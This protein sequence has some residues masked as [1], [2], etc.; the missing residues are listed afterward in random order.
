MMKIVNKFLL[1]F[2]LSF[3]CL[4]GAQPSLSA[5]SAKGVFPQDTAILT[6]VS[7]QQIAAPIYF[8]LGRSDIDPSF[9]GNSEQIDQFVTSLRSILSN[10][11]YVISKVRVVGTAS[12]DGIRERNEELAGARARALSDLLMERASLPADKIEV[13]NGGENWQGLRAMIESSDEVPDKSKM[14]EFMDWYDGD[15]DRMKQSMQFYNGSRAWRWMY[16]HFFPIL[17][18]GAGGASGGERLSRLSITNWQRIRDVIHDL[19]LDEETKR[20]MYNM[21]DQTA[22][23]TKTGAVDVVRQLRE[24]SPDQEAYTLLERQAVMELLSGANALSADNWAQLRGLIAASDM[25]TKEEALHIIDNVP[26]AQREEQLRA[27]NGGNTFNYIAEHFYPRLLTSEEQTRQDDGVTTTTLNAE[28]WRK[29][30]DMVAASDMPAKAEV[31][32]VIDSENDPAVRERKLHDLNGGYP[33]RY[34]QEVFF[35]EL[36]YD[37]SSASK[38]NWQLFEEQVLGSDLPNKEK[39]LEI[40]RTRPA[41]APREA[42]IRALDDSRTWNELSRMVLPELLQSTDDVEAPSGTGM[43]FT[44]EA[45]PAAKARAE[46]LRLRAEREAAERAEQAR[47]EEEQRRK[48]EQE[49]LE[50]ER[51]R[52]EAEAEQARREAVAQLKAQRQESR[53]MTPLLG[54]KTDLVMWGGLMSGFKMGAW[55]PNLSAEVYFANQ[56]SAQLGWAYSYWDALSGSYG[57]F[58]SS[59]LDLEIRWWLKNDRLFRGFFAGVYGTYG[60]YD[61]QDKEQPTGQTGT[62]FGAGIGGGW[63]QPLSRHWSLEAQVRVGYRSASNELYDIETDHYYLDRKQNE[64]RFTPQLRIQFVYRFGRGQQ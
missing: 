52:A 54:I 14:L 24:L 63:L 22:S 49:R 15:R 64:G 7:T 56:W 2:L 57:Q 28:N 9:M 60:D 44:F 62:F 58:A 19:D 45:S 59:A 4:A 27:L 30:R 53:K 41:G 6:P 47:L 38:E 46:A 23:E 61:V 51:A 39:V 50:A 43:S 31:L 12:P 16:K 1:V 5:D 42:A 34:I 33:Y 36:L 8:R 18:T 20:A 55:T 21:L 11:D 26:I 17:R 48:A 3:S 10:P 25:P 13:V 32:S 37:I 29:L 35:P 40:L